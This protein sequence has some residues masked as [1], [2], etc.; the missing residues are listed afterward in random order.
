MSEQSETSAK[1]ALEYIK[2]LFQKRASASDEEEATQ[3]LIE[4]PL[5]VAVRSEWVAPGVAMKPREYYILLGTGGPATR[6]VGDLDA[7]GE[8]C[9]ARLQ[10]QDWFETCRSL[11]VS[12]EDE[13]FLLEFAN[14]FYFG[15]GHE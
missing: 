5:E 2:E 3:E 6:V 8:P 9:T 14:L 7:Y 15:G 4:W 11:I 1:N 10:H 12:E 13:R